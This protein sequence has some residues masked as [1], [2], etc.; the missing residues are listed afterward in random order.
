MR[1]IASKILAIA[2]W[3]ILWEIA[4]SLSPLLPRPKALL[5]CVARLFQTGATFGVLFY[6]ILHIYGGFLIA[7]LIGTTLATVAFFVPFLKPAIGVLVSFFRSIPV[8]GLTILLVI[9]TSSHVLPWIVVVGMLFPIFYE[10]AL[11]G[12]AAA[13]PI[14]LE[15]AQLYHFSSSAIFRHIRMPKLGEF[16]AVACRTSMGIA[17]KAAV[18]AEVIAM[19]RGGFGEALY[20]AKLTLDT[21]ELFSWILILIFF[22][23]LSEIAMMRIVK[24]FS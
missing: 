1:S 13:D 14:K 9:F 22:A 15:M 16:L 2:F 8:A 20:Y 3:L 23:K 17:W 5:L 7:V 12:Y 10:A 21:E 4:A 11:G 6:S 18:A 24:R 19:T